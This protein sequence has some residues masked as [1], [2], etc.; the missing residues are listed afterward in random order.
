MQDKVLV[1]VAGSHNGKPGQPSVG[2]GV[3]K[4]VGVVAAAY[5]GP[6]PEAIREVPV[7]HL[8]QRA[9]EGAQADHVARDHVGRGGY[10]HAEGAADGPVHHTADHGHQSLLCEPREL[11]RGAARRVQPSA[12]GVH[13]L[14]IVG[15]R[16]PAS[17]GGQTSGSSGG[18]GGRC[19][20]QGRAIRVRVREGVPA[21]KAVLNVRD[22]KA[23]HCDGGV[24][25][26]E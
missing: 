13:V 22:R 18:L 17:L 9:D 16:A 3:E 12:G 24:E 4:T 1:Q 19:E 6:L 7:G 23:A 21:D 26:E 20:P 25:G 11:D 14:W 8:G 2:E 10:P 5:E 15:G